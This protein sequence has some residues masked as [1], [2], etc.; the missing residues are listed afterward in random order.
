MITKDILSLQTELRQLSD[1]TRSDLI[2]LPRY[3]IPIH[4]YSWEQGTR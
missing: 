2:D 1:E 4:S 3:L